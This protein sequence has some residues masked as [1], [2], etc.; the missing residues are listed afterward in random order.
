MQLCSS[1]DAYWELGHGGLS[2]SKS[3]SPDWETLGLRWVLAPHLFAV[4]GDGGQ[5]GAQ[6]LDAHGDVQQVTGEE[7]VVVVTQQGHD[8]VP[9]QVQ[10]RLHMGVICHYYFHYCWL[11]IT[12]VRCTSDHRMQ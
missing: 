7:E 11:Y 8:Q 4:V 3:G 12:A 5:D 1:G 10:E 2:F 9:A 6:G